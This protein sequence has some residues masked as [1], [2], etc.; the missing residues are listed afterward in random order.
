[1]RGSIKKDE[2]QNK[3]IYFSYSFSKAYLYKVRIV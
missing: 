3:A 1:M 2:I